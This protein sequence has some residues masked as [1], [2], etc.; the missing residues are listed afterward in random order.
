MELKLFGKNIFEFRGGRANYLLNEGVA[1]LKESKYLPD[2]HKDLGGDIVQY[3][4]SDDGR[5]TQASNKKVKKGDITITPKGVYQLKMLNEEGFKIKTSPDYINN[6]I[7]DFKEKLGMVKKEEYDMN[8]AVIE[9]QSILIRLENRKKY[10]EFD[11]FYSQFAYTTSTKIKGVLGKCDNLKIGQVAQFVPDMPKEAIEAM[12]EYTKQT[13]ELCQKEPVYYIIAEKKDF[14][15]TEKRR[16]PILLAQSPFGHFWQI[17]GAWD[18]EMLL[19][20]DL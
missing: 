17:L 15:K 9:I 1:K 6:Q 16:D 5:A 18:K 3:I 11:K 7:E 14:E 19:L 4:I 12:K 10:P 13:K 8:R 2:F 20:E